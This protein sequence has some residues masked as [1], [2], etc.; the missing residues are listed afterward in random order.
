MIA[1]FL[2]WKANHGAVAAQDAGGIF[3]SAPRPI[4]SQNASVAAL[5]TA[6][7]V[8]KLQVATQR[9]LVLAL[10]QVLT[11]QRWL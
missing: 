11:L 6:S 3:N 5:Q 1:L 7:V 9:L 8:S 2:A 4:V 10:A